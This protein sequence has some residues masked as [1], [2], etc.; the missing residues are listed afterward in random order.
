[1]ARG[2]KIDVNS[3]RHRKFCKRLENVDRYMNAVTRGIERGNKMYTNSYDVALAVIT[4]LRIDGFQI[5]P[6][7]TRKGD[8]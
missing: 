7:P 2:R 8:K 5:I 4:E 1:M 6:H 3:V